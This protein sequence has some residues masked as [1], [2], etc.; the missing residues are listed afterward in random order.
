VCFLNFIPL[1]DG[2]GGGA[3]L[4]TDGDGKKFSADPT[5]GHRSK[6]LHRRLAP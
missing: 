6:I 1:T 4:P 5:I 2:G 3:T